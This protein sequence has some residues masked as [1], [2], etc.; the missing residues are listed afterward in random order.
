MCDESSMIVVGSIGA[1]HGI[2]GW[3]RINSFT[4]SPEAIF[5]YEPWVIELGG[6]QQSI[7]VKQ[8]KV[9]HKSFIALFGGYDSP[10]TAQSLVNAEIRIDSEHLAELPEG[11]YYWQDL[12]GCQVINLQGYH[13]GQVAQIMETGAN[14][15]LCVTANRNDAFH[16]QERLIPMIEAQ[17]IKQVDVVAK[18]ITVDWQPDF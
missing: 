11:D 3:V 13:L 12:I 7:Q 16:K 14:D 1:V 17:F 15:V 2:K 6:R 10:E 5:S 18:T 8:W 9:H 4:D